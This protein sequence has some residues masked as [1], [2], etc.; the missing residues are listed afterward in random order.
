MIGA[1]KSFS[2]LEPRTYTNKITN[3][4]RVI[5]DIEATGRS[6]IAGETDK[7][8]IIVERYRD[9][10]L[11]IAWRLS[12]NYEDSLDIAQEALLRIFR[13]L[14]SWRGHARFSTW[15]YRVVLNT[16]IDY[17]HW[18]SKHFRGR[19]LDFGDD[20][21]SFLENLHGNTD[22]RTP[23]QQTHIAEMK[24]HIFRALEKL[25]GRQQKCVL[26]KYFHDMKISEIA[27]VLEIKEGTVK[28]HL[29]RGL[30][31][32]HQFLSEYNPTLR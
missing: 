8:E 4:V 26:L 24:R 19:I 28:R 3:E 21:S 22:V 15:M 10:I 17:V 6:I 5:E 25:S 13:A 16:A 31:K 12:G 20:P 23:L 1:A 18:Q 9:R 7:F 29:Y 30:T 2:H 32:L 27:E 14:K 11:N